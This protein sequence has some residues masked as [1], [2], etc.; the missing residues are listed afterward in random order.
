MALC[1]GC[2]AEI[3]EKDAFCRQCGAKTKSE[4]G[5]LSESGQKLLAQYEEFRD[6]L[7]DMDSIAKTGEIDPDQWKRLQEEGQLIGGEFLKLYEKETQNL[8]EA[9]KKEFEKAYEQVQ[10]LTK[11][12]E[13]AVE[14]QEPGTAKVN[15]VCPYCYK[16]TIEEL[17]SGLAEH[18]CPECNKSF[19]YIL[20]IV[21]RREGRTRTASFGPPPY[22][23]RVKTDQGDM[24]VFFRTEM[25]ID[26]GKGDQVFFGFTKKFLGKGY[27]DEPAVLLNFTLASY[28]VL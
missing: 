14:S 25:V 10:G 18:T 17:I 15:F 22:T 12:L 28:T 9:E 27:K 4:E 2:G 20:G 8:N 21:K 7:A 6:L 13:K 3:D 24:S 23:V 1:P 26:V 5:Q 11:N 19:Q 16:Q